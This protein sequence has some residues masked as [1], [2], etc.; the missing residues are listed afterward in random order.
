MTTTGAARQRPRADFAQSFTADNKP[1][2]RPSLR[3]QL[4][5]V[6][7]GLL[8]G[9][10]MIELGARLTDTGDN[11]D[12]EMWKYAR[13]LKRVSANPAIAHEHRP[14]SSAILMG[15]PVTINSMGLRDREYTLAKPPGVTRIVMLGDSLTF[16]WG[17]KMDDTPAKLLEASLNAGLPKPG[18]EV[19][20]AGVGNYNSTMEVAYFLDHGQRFK[21]DIVVLNYFINDAELTPRRRNS[22]LT[23]HSHAAVLAGSAIDKMERQY[24][25][26]SDWKT[27]YRDLYRPNMQG[28][29]KARAAISELALYCQRN[30]IKLLVANYPEL[31]Q[32][33]PYP[34]QDVTDAI[35]QAAR[36]NGVQFVDIRPAVEGLKPSILWVTPDDAHPNRTANVR[37]AAALHKALQ[38]DLI[39]AG[40]GKAYAP[41]KASGAISKVSKKS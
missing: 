16:G 30:G 11:F 1:R 8:L 35:G 25:G 12:I 2:T 4:L 20:N 9:G 38:L 5:T 7:L 39:A 15:V 24:F 13:D 37:I 14:N 6:A 10:A 3:M 26:K 28:W 17:V 33:S 18:Y 34:F 19:I 29:A 21:P 23:E 22:F 40:S 41:S 36:S 32:L 31:H 27:Y